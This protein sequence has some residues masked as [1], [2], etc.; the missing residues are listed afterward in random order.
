MRIYS[1]IILS[2]RKCRNIILPSEIFPP[3]VARF[4][5]ILQWFRI[6]LVT[7]TNWADAT[8]VKVEEELR[9]IIQKYRQMKRTGRH[10]PRMVKTL[11]VSK[12]PLLRGNR[13]LCSFII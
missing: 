13:K 1:Y 10:E 7:L 11:R 9:A 12:F 6:K 8:R 3:V 4:K 5:L 2:G